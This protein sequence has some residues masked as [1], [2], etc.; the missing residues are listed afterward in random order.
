MRI[1]SLDFFIPLSLLCGLEDIEEAKNELPSHNSE[2]NKHALNHGLLDD[3]TVN[4]LPTLDEP[5]SI[6]G[7]Y[8]FNQL[9]S[10]ISLTSSLGSLSCVHLVS[11][12]SA[13]LDV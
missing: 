2:G 5:P 10:L 4:F 8:G 3:R 1:C 13:L 12:I 6:E 7:L 9:F 11:Y